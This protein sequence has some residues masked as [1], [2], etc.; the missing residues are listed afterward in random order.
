MNSRQAFIKKL[1]SH[2]NVFI[3]SPHFDDAVLSCGSLIEKLIG[4]KVNV[5]IINIF[6]KAHSGPYTLSA[7][8]FL[9]DSN[10]HTDAVKLFEER[11]QEDMEALKKLGVQ[12]INLDLADALF[13]KKNTFNFMAK[14]LPELNHI[15]PTYRWHVIKNVAK[16]DIAISQLE[17]KLT[18]FADKNAVFIIPYGIGNHADHK[19]TRKVCEKILCNKQFIIYSDFPY[20]IRTNR[21]G[22][23]PKGWKRISLDIDYKQKSNIINMYG[24]QIN[25]LFKDGI[26]PNHKEIYF[27]KSQWK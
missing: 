7:K 27:Y 1:S 5:T 17:S 11:H 20:N 26:V 21:F 22:V 14:I 19:I 6:T 13:R 23:C 3:V 10:K 9:N 2:K 16:D 15:Y 4:Q 12:L 24:T 18:Q 25:G 8:K